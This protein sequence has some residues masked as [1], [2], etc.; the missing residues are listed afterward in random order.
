MT[1]VNP[2]PSK[3]DDDE[4]SNLQE[5]AESGSYV[6]EPTDPKDIFTPETDYDP[7]DEDED[8]DDE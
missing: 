4:P 8:E 2:I 3:S 6:D 7:D 1:E 5:L